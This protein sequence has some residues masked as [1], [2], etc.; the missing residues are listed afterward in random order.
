LNE[1]LIE[2][3]FINIESGYFNSVKSI[4][5]H[6]NISIPTVYQ[7]L[8]EKTWKKVSEKFNMAIIRSLVMP[9]KHY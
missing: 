4:S 9:K 6:Y 8:N 1:I 2:E 7:I 3:M 5:D